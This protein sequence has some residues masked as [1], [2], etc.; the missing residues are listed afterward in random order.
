[1]IPTRIKVGRKKYEV[2]IVSSLSRNKRGGWSSNGT[3]TLSRCDGLGRVYATK[4]VN[5]AFWHEITHAI[6]HDMEHP[7][8]RNEKFVEAFAKR[9]ADTI[10][11]AEFK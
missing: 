10:H 11:S 4:K 5:E 9:L 6:L 2:N 8:W 1:M 7:L 3:I